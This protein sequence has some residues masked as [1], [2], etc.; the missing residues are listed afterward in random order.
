MRINEH[1]LD[2]LFRKARTARGFVNEAVPLALLHEIYQLTCLGPT[3][4]NS[5][6]ARF[7]F[8]TTPGAKE[9]LVPALSPA[10]VDK[11]RAAPVTVIVAYDSHFYD[12]FSKTWHVPTV[13]DN[14]ANNAAHAELTAVRNG[15]LQGAY[16]ILAARALGLDCGPMSGFSLDKVNTEFFPDGRWRAN[17]L[18]N[19]GRAD[20]SKTPPERSPRL[21][22]EEAC[23][24][25]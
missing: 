8:L 24:V 15:S 4:Q 6:P 2:Q 13:R 14:Y 3:T 9:R 22:F 18:C 20:A 21:G 16:L 12:L 11:T 23:Q 1:A 17:F 25:L 19:L 7:I 10:N 5:Q